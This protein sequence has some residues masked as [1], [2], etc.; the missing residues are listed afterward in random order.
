MA[1][2]NRADYLEAANGNLSAEVE[3]LNA[4]LQDAERRIEEQNSRGAII[5]PDVPRGNLG[6][7][8]GTRI[9]ILE[10]ENN[11]L[12]NEI[13]KLA[14]RNLTTVVVSAVLLLATLAACIFI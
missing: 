5:V 1:N 6:H 2:S 12:N 4:K 13:K 9:N 11:L 3:K 7:D 14:K 10:K 8:S